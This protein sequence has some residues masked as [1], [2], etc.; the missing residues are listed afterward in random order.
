MSNQATIKDKFE[1][2]YPAMDEKMCRLW[3]ANEAIAQGWG[4]ESLVSA[5]T[6]LSLATIRSGVKELKRLALNARDFVPRQR[7]CG[8]RSS[9][10]NRRIR[11]SGGGRK[12]TELKN[13]GILAALEQLVS[14]EVGGDPMTKQRWVRSSLQRLSSRL[15]E[16]GFQASEGTV[17]R[18]LRICAAISPQLGCHGPV[19]AALWPRTRAVP[20]AA[21]REAIPAQ[22]LSPDI[23]R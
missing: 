9:R 3:A 14:G 22:S 11:R 19:D 12:L 6:G 1:R 2:L 13:P 23:S 21:T 15:K 8:S 18:L 7:K 4:G 20:R 10:Q 16:E 17:R 5:A